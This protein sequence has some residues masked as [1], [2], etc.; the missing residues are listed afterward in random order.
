MRKKSLIIVFIILLSLLAACSGQLN[1]EISSKITELEGK[2]SII[3][4]RLNDLDSPNDQAQ[5][6]VTQS[7][8]PTESIDTVTTDMHDFSY[9]TVL[10]ILNNLHITDNIDNTFVNGWIA[11]G[12][13]D[14]VFLYLVYDCDFSD[15][16][17]SDLSNA[18]NSN[19]T[20]DT[21]IN[22]DGDEAYIAFNG[23]TINIKT[24]ENGNCAFGYNLV[25][26]EA[27]TK[28]KELNKVYFN[29]ENFLIS[30]DIISEYGFNNIKYEYNLD[31]NS[32]IS[33]ALVVSD[34]SF[35][36][37]NELYDYYSDKF[38]GENVYTM[39]SSDEYAETYSDFKDGVQIKFAAK[40]SDSEDVW[41]LTISRIAE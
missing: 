24:D 6:S 34:A 27:I 36:A 25:E 39:P 29:Y 8:D 38:N 18:V 30:Q 28:I 26:N 3:E 32:C 7:A 41:E 22:F 5:V 17:K 11:S 15:E 12:P 23:N 40:P 37:V 21:G 14:G 35:E 20:I 4:K 1:N 19:A 16:V 31:A 33:T 9:S 13:T 2:I 10:E